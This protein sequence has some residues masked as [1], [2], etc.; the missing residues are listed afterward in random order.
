MK[1]IIK[2]KTVEYRVFQTSDG[3]EFEDAELAR[4]HEEK[5]NGNIK[6]CPTC[7]GKKRIN[8]RF[9]KEWHNTSWVPTQGE[10]VKVEKSDICTN[11]NGKGYLEMKWV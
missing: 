11:C 7:S 10:Y 5:L 9:E 4:I 2:T 8:F 6:T 3:K 1:P